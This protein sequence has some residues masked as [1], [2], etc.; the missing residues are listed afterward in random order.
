[1]NIRL[2]LVCSLGLGLVCQG[3]TAWGQ[4]KGSSKKPAP[5]KNEPIKLPQAVLKT[6]TEKVMKVAPV[7]RGKRS[8]VEEA[9]AKIDAL[10]EASWAKYEV[11]ASPNLKDEQFL[12]RIYLELGGR[13]PT[14]FEAMNFIGS[15]TKDKRSELIDSMLESP[16]YVSHFYNYWADILRLCE[17]PQPNVIMDPYLTYVKDCIRENKP[18]D[19]WVHEML[20]AEGKIWEN[21]AVGFQIRDDGMPLPYIDNTVRVFLGTQIG[22]AQ[23]HDHPFDIW[24]QKQFYELAAFT[25]GT[26]T[27]LGGGDPE[28]K[29][30][31]PI[32]Q[33]IK[34][35]QA[36]T[37]D[38][39]V[40]GS[41]QQM[42][43]ANQFA[44]RYAKRDLK[45]PHDYAYSD[46]KPNQVVKAKVLWGEVPAQAEK[47]T[48]REQFAAWIAGRSNRQFARNI[49]NRMWQKMM[50]VGIVE[51]VDDFRKNNPPTNPELLEHLT[52][53][54]IRLNYDVRE[55]VRV[56][57]YTKAYQKQA[58]V[59]DASEG[60][61]YRFPSPTM[62][63][64]TAEQLWDSLLTLVAYNPWSYQRPSAQEIAKTVNIDLAKA[65]LEE[66]EKVHAEYAET[67]FPGKYNSN[68]QKLC[69]F[70]GQLLVRASEIPTPV[71]LGHF[72]RQFGQSDRQAIE[73][74]ST[75]AT[76]PQILTMFN[77]PITHILL[78]KGSVIYDNVV[79]AGPAKAVD[80]IFVT[81]L[82]HRPNSTDRELAQTEIKNSERPEE[83]YG[84]VIWALLNTREFIFIQ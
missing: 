64:M 61:P 3:A 23:C 69:G 54:V 18:Y 31:N 4:A 29:G 21:P 19:K 26:R 28:F 79:M 80:V 8:Q 51:P 55:L 22:C 2:I 73:A 84:N 36:K 20:T 14:Y 77:G 67:Y 27:R 76:I 24:T 72:L 9:A 49:A 46:A 44:V 50:G 6:P 35:A 56:I 11:S 75:T 1:M 52:D 33:L 53:E 47:A 42:I 39:K 48:P 65:K 16:D 37:P 60:K 5:P 40:S 70:K 78:E 10:L 63:R 71:P 34:D 59:Y 15:K 17:R 41:L 66:V 57:A 83:G 30:G 7:D 68:I 38:G 25:S 12:R 74:S 82:S 62:R 13:I 43:R 58:T 81:I 32:N 45:L